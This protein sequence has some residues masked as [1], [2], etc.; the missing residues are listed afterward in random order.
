MLDDHVKV[1][2]QIVLEEAEE[3]EPEPKEKIM[4]ALKLAGGLGIKVSEDIGWNEQ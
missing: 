2:K 3:P 1:R 4:R